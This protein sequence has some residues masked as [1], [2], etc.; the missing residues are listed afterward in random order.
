MANALAHAV[1]GAALNLC[2]SH[3]GA[4]AI[5]VLDLVMKGRQGQT[6]DFTEVG[7]RHASLADPASAFGQIVAAPLDHGMTAS[8]WAAFTSDKADPVLRDA[9]LGVWRAE[10]YGVRF[11]GR[12]SVTVEGLP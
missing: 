4:P 2:R 10:I 9:C 6:L 5:D 12:Y 8:E 1:V 11:C 3:P 7:A